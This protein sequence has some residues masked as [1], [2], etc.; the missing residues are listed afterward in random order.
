MPY[1]T[2][3]EILLMHFRI[4]TEFQPYAN[5]YTITRPNELESAIAR[6][7][8]SAG[9]EDAYN[10]DYEKAAA[11][12]ESLINNHPFQDGNKRV[13]ITAGCVFLLANGYHEE[14]LNNNDIEECALN[15]SQSNWR[16]DELKKWFEKHFI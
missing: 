9:G 6:P 10:D 16:F 7:Q 14:N 11:L 5:I 8:Q 12:T 1:L 4:I 15:V 2:I 13:G 3:E